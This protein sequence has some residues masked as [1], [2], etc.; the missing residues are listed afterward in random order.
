MSSARALLPPL[1][2][3]GVAC[4]QLWLAHAEA[5]SP[6]SGGGFGMFSTQDAGSR[7]HLHVFAHHEGIRRELTL[8]RSLAEAAARASAL[9]S[10]ARLVA[11]ARR[12]DADD[13]DFGRPAALEV[14]VYATRFDRETLAPRGVLLRSIEVPLADE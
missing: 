5:L 14:Q 1:L 3:V 13:P 4:T 6:W 8:P 11:L 7:R 10:R 2:L 12:L 9:P